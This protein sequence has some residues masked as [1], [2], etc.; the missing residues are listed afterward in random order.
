MPPC[1]VCETPANLLKDLPATFLRKSLGDYFK[2]QIPESVNIGSYQLMQCPRCTAEFTE[3]MLPGDASFYAWIARKAGYYPEWR[4]EWDEVIATIKGR[5]GNQAALLEVGCGSGTFLKVVLGQPAIHAVGLDTEPGSIASCREKGC[6]AHCE[7]IS[8]F[9]ARNPDRRFDYAVAFHCLEH[10]PKP[11]DFLNA[12]LGALRAGGSVF[13][14]TPYSPMSFE[15][16]WFDPLN[17]PPHHMTR[18]NARMYQEMAEQLGLG[19]RL[20]MPEPRSLFQR[21]KDALAL[22]KFGPRGTFSRF[23]RYAAL[24]CDPGGLISEIL[25]QRARERLDGICT[26]DVVL[27]EFFR[28][29]E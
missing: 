16:G 10:V 17:H 3:P 26:A 5:G 20:R 19:M 14:S 1:P 29:P 21:T 15:T 27:V 7:E 28:K 6:E 22:R 25:R 11:K 4:W 18:W 2:E 23:A 13:V 12:M 9:L 8:A 24:A